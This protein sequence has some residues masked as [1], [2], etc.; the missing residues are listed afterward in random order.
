M[1]DFNILSSTLSAD[2]VIPKGHKGYEEASKELNSFK[3][4]FPTD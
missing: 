4:T 1:A 2:Q 3:G